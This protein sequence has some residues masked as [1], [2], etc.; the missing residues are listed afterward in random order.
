MSNSDTTTAQTAD[1]SV[2]TG[3]KNITL[4]NGGN[5]AIIKGTSPPVNITA[6]QGKDT[7]LTSGNNVTSDLTSGATKIVANAGNVRLRMYCNGR[8]YSN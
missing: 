3:K 4:G 1:F 2:S 8:G 6:G 5:L 7:I